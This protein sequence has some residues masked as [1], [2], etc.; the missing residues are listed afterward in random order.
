M[1]RYATLLVMLVLVPGSARA[2]D[3]TNLWLNDDQRGATHMRA[4]DYEAAAHAFDD[5]RWRAA[6]LYRAGDYAAAAGAWSELDDTRSHYNRGNA[7]ARAGRLA[8][9]VAAY[10]TVLAREPGHADARHNLALLRE[11]MQDQQQPDSPQAGR[12]GNDRQRDQDPQGGKDED[13]SGG[14]DGREQE[15]RAGASGDGAGQ[16]AQTGRDRREAGEL[17]AEPGQDA[18]NDEPDGD[19]RGATAAEAPREPADAGRRAA[20]AVER[21]ME[22]GAERRAAMDQWLRRIP[23]DPGGLL[24]RKFRYQYQR[25]GRGDEEV[26]ETW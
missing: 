18:R 8:E 6:A 21:T 2:L 9:A 19:R 17:P 25:R 14:E 16:R 10:E 20:G 24:R 11:L 1:S 12:D 13:S 26:R 5:P 23:D 7:L 15:R 22:T 3:W 4:E